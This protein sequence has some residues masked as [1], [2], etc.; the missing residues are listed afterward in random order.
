MSPE[1]VFKPPVPSVEGARGDGPSSD[2]GAEEVAAEA[3]TRARTRQLIRRATSAE[4]KR[5]Q[6][7]QKRE[8]FAPPTDTGGLL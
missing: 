5:R 7:I 2:D 1:E 3:N 8:S 6:M 4:I